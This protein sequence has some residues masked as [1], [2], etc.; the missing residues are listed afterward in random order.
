LSSGDRWETLYTHLSRIDVR[1]GEWVEAGDPIGLS[2]NSGCSTGPH[3]HF[4]VRRFTHTNNQDPVPIDPYGWLGVGPD[5]WALHP[6]GAVSLFLWKA[7]QAPPL[8]RIP[9][10][11]P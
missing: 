10:P 9:I 6:D 5:P 11:Q 7:G 3:L 4:E 2:G 1:E 8:C